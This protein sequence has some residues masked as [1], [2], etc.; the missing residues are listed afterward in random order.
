[1]KAVVSHSGGMDSSLCLKIAID[2]W[3]K[4]EVISLGFDY[5]QRQKSE[6]EA[7]RIIAQA[8]G[9]ERFVVPLPLLSLLQNNALVDHTRAIEG[10]NTLVAGRNGLFAWHA[11]LVAHQRGAAEV[12]MGVMELESANSGYRDCSRAYMDLVQQIL[13]LDLADSGFTI[14][15]PLVYMTKLQSLELAH[16]LGILDFLLQETVT[17]YE[18]LKGRGCTTCPACQLKN[19]GIALY[20]RTRGQEDFVT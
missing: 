5:G 4:E 18:G 16:S 10:L 13:R 1:M 9:V 15:T 3:G 19:E 2:K 12:Y 17:C 8:F 14:V 20:A 11:A 7:A 6:Q